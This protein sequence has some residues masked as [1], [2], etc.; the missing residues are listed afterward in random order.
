VVF[1]V[2]A[3]ATQGRTQL[4]VLR[5]ILLAGLLATVL[6]MIATLLVEGSWPAPPPEF[7]QDAEPLFPVMRVAWVTAAIVAAVPHFTRPVRRLGWLIILIVAISGFG[8]GFGLP[9]DIVGGF[10]LGLATASAVLL[11][12]GS[13]R[14]YPDIAVVSATS[15]QLGFGIAD[16]TPVPDRSWG[17]R[18][19]A[20]KLVDGSPIAIKAYGRDAADA[21][22]LSRIWRT[23]WYRDT[24]GIFTYSRLHS[25][26]HEALITMMADRRSVS[27]P[28]VLGTG[29]SEA[30]ALLAVTDPGAPLSATGDVGDDDLAA[31]WSQVAIMHGA[32]IAHGALGLDAVTIAPGGIVIRDFNKATLQPSDDLLSRDVVELLFAT[33]ATL[34]VDRAVAAARRGLGDEVLTAALPF[35]QL[36]AVS[37]QTRG[38]AEKPSRAMKE[39]RSHLSEAIGAELPEPV[40]LRRVTWGNILMLALLLIAA[41]ALIGMLTDIDFAAVW[42]VVQD[43]TW[44][45]IVVGFV[46]GQTVFFPQAGSMLYAVGAPLPMGPLTVLQVAVKFIGLAVP[47]A[48]GRIAMNAAF[49]RKYGVS[50][51]IAVTQGAIDGVAGFI[52][53]AGILL[54]ALIS[55]D[56]ALDLDLDDAPWG[57]II[58]IVAVVI[59]GLVVVFFRVQRVRTTVGP[60]IGEVW[61]LLK[62]IAAEPRRAIGLFG[63]NLVSRMILGLTLWFVMQGI[64]FPISYWEALTVT[65]ATNLLAGLVPIPGGI[66]VAEAVLTSFLILVGV[67][68]AEAFAGAVVFR[69]ATFYL[70]A[71]A[72]FPAMRWLERRDYL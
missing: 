43:A 56:L 37:P 30:V 53:E 61:N 48:A 49:L 22:L 68:E 28:Y 66:G 36:P 10:G 34:G 50:A 8:L 20:G 23:L 38:L 44:T 3:V 58:L 71:V 46:I 65:V 31:A 15:D 17:V 6:A 51:A 18:R 57:L 29:E 47:S 60:I 24:G 21:Q 7:R 64:H 72:G 27:V 55:A 26:E 42:E 41:N 19:L 13:P 4:E 5:D 67:P 40:K 54:V 70:P 52:V 59:V 25:V 12:F 11:V 1:L 35:V 62:G 69:V 16:I 33:A 9:S 2:V 45:W 32:G 14:G 39:L 63:N